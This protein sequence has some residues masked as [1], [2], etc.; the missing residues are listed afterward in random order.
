M[1][2]SSLSAR[3]AAVAFVLALAAAAGCS[4]GPQVH[5]FGGF[6]M[7]STYEVKFVGNVPL[8]E[9]R[10]AVTGLLAE[11]DL[12]FSKWRED[13][14][15]SRLNAAPGAEPFAVSP[16]FAAVLG[17][18]LEVARQTGGA[19]DPTVQPLLALYRQAKADPGHHL[20]PA[21]LDEARKLVDYRK[22]AVQ[23][24][25][26]RRAGEGIQLD[27]DGLVAGACLDAIAVRLDELGVPAYYL[28][29]TG[30]VFCRGEKAPGNPWRIG[31]VDPRAGERLD[32]PPITAMPLRD[33]SL[34]TSGDYRNAIEVDGRKVHHV[35]DPRTGRS[36]EHDVVSVTVLAD[37]AAVADALGTAFLVL[38]VE[39]TRAACQRLEGEPGFAGLGVLLL[40]KHGAGLRK[41]GIG[42]PAGE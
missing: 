14:E 4:R 36:T 35:F 11:F 13:S 8:A 12:A 2:P 33:R 3:P 28:E 27:L 26:V 40:E 31:I 29:V 9:V 39:G 20:D 42:W 37:S 32:E 34:C 16:R 21:A 18:A 5:S 30:E 1:L 41:I 25:E 6:T 17:Q 15:I 7:G 19:F 38:G 23:D 24:G 22:V 10:D